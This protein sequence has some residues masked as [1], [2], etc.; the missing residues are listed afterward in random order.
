MNVSSQLQDLHFSSVH[1]ILNIWQYYLEY[2]WYYDSSSWVAKIAYT[3]RVFAVLFILPATILGMLDISS[4]LIARTLGVVDVAKASTSDKPVVIR[5][6]I[7]SIRIED[8]SSSSA[9]TDSVLSDESNAATSP[10]LS[11]RADDEIDDFVQLAEL[12]N[13]MFSNEE[14]AGVG[15]FS[16]AS[17]CPPSPT[18]SRRKMVSDSNSFGG[19]PNVPLQDQRVR[20]RSK[21]NLRSAG[22]DG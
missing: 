4:Y 22:Q 10:E 13:S 1:F 14:L 12:N 7:P 15:V 20:R 5:L 18:L 8:T 6:T 3:I 9:V 2:L 17:S 16:P 21:R 19:Q 11:D